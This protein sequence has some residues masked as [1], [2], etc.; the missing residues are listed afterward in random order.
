[1]SESTGRVDRVSGITYVHIPARDPVA[2]AAFYRAVFDWEIRGNP[3]HPS[4]SDGTGDVIGA[5]VTDVPVAGDAGIVPYVYVANVDETLEKVTGQGG[6]IAKAP[7]PEGDL[8]VATF[9]DPAGNVIGVWQ[10][11]SH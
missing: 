10:F 5:W 11:E 2:S 9:R 8:R 6:L 3:Q 1:M 4:F 7:Y